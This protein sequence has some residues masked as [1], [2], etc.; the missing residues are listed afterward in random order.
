MIAA[1]GDP[2]ASTPLGVFRI[3]WSLISR[4]HRYRYLDV[5]RRGMLEM[6]DD[7]HS[8]PSRIRAAYSGLSRGHGTRQS[9]RA[10]AFSGPRCSRRCQR[11]WSLFVRSSEGILSM[12]VRFEE[13]STSCVLARSQQ[14]CMGKPHRCFWRVDLYMRGRRCALQ[15]PRS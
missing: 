13:Q 8:S 5:L 14:A 1:Q 7:L 2:P 6:E 12:H 3:C 4:G 11:L 15:D 9:C 10:S